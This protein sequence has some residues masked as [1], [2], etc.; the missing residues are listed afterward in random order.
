MTQGRQIKLD[1][2]VNVAFTLDP[3]AVE[4]IDSNRGKQSRSGFLNDLILETCTK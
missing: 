1:K 4:L 3:K 2:K